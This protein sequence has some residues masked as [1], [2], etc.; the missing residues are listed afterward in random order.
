M[1]A[2]DSLEEGPPNVFECSTMFAFFLNIEMFDVR[3]FA[4]IQMFKSSNV[5]MFAYIRMFNVRMFFNFFS[6]THVRVFECSPN[7]N[8]HSNIEQKFSMFGDPMFMTPATG[9]DILF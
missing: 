3:M 6:H 1:I 9:L 2:F 5:R 8:E 4:N 7:M